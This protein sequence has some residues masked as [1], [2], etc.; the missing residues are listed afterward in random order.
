MHKQAEKYFRTHPLYNAV[1]HVIGGI[2]IGILITYPFVGS[3]PLRWGAILLL[4]S[5]LGHLYPSTIKK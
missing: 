2:G 5:L 4:L 3:H 1:V